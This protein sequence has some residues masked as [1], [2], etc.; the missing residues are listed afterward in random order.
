[1]ITFEP[2]WETLKEKNISK[3]KLINTYGL[4]RG[5]LNS[6]MHNQNVTLNTLNWLCQVLEC[7]V[8]KIIKYA[9]D[10]PEKK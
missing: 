8:T 4:S 1:M 3:Y 2:L 7:D 10:E 9:P 6:L 5:T